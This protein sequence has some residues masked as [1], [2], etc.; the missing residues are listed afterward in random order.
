M[1]LGDLTLRPTKFFLNII[2]KTFPLLVDT[3]A[4]QV[5]TTKQRKNKVNFT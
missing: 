5:K 1:K 3:E 2:S 4:D